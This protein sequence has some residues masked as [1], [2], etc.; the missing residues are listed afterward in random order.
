MFTSL[1][2]HVVQFILKKMHKIAIC[3]FLLVYIVEEAIYK[4]RN[5]TANFVL[6]TKN[7]T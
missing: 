4:L 1:M 2:E 6:G 7:R 3:T 5:K